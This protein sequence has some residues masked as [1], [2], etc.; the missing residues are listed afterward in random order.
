MI[1]KIY[2]NPVGKSQEI[3]DLQLNTDQCLGFVVI[4]VGKCL[5]FCAAFEWTQ[6]TA[7]ALVQHS[8]LIIMN[9]WG[10]FG[11]IYFR[12][13]TTTHT[14]WRLFLCVVIVESLCLSW[15]L[16]L[17]KIFSI[18]VMK[19]WEI[20]VSFF[21]AGIHREQVHG[22]CSPSSPASSSFPQIWRWTWTVSLTFRWGRLRICKSSEPLS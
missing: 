11:T 4:W 14:G 13:F 8:W 1:S 22:G 2:W 5:I 10:F 12:G 18:T 21:K 17:K 6:L 16:I 7:S 15:S 19:N 9:W 20:M 3:A